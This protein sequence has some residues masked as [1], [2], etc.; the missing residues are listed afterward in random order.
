MKKKRTFILGTVLSVLA[1]STAAALS[2][3]VLA[4]EGEK[5]VD[6]TFIK[7]ADVSLLQKVER[8]G[9]T[10][11]DN[12]VEKDALEILKDNGVNY[13][14]LKIWE[15]PV[16]VGGAN[17]LEETVTMAQRVKEHDMGFL[18]N[19]HYSNF[20]AD[21]E[22]QNKPTAWEDLTFDELVDV[23]YDHTAETLQVLEEVDG[24]PDMIQIGNEI[25]SGMLWPDG[26]TWGE[27]QGVD[28][29]GFENL[30]QL[31][32]AGIDAVHDTLPENHSV[33][34]MLHLAD[35]GDN[36]L[37]RW[38]FDEM[39]AHGVHD[40]DVIGLSYYP[41]WHG[42]LNDLQANL[43]DISERYNKDVIVVETSYAHTLEEG[44][45]FPNIFGT[46]E[47]VE[48][49]YPATVEG[50]TAFLEDVMSVIHGVPNDH[51]RGFFYWEPTWI[52][53]ENAGWKDGEGNAW[54]NQTLFDF[55]GNALPSLK[56]F[57]E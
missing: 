41:Y 9:G 27:E 54:D 47:E 55:D 11:Y 15:D 10:F 20:W 5:E 19:F 46:E 45:G 37:Y 30:L 16:N 43:N 57:N 44:D 56:I 18:L 31:V 34:I 17:D 2:F 12:G 49:G 32:N 23:V 14:R 53:A 26:K 24:L 50:Q 7:G 21:P 35:G 13:I 36:D 8:G 51:G 3:T 38:W 42:S 22:R 25:Q 52:P 48:G 29:G 39:L 1:F 4:S 40:F 6:E 33:E 28:Y